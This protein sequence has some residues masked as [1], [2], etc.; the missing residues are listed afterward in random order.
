MGN[1]IQSNKVVTSDLLENV[2]GASIMNKEVRA[3]L[4]HFVKVALSVGLTKKNIIAMI[5]HMIMHIRNY[6]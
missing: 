3:K 1:I 4:E 2:I 5:T 6:K